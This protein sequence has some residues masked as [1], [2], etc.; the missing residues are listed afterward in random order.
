MKHS[1]R[2]LAAVAAGVT[3]ALTLTAGSCDPQPQQT[4]PC[5]E[6]DGEECDDDPFDF[7]DFGKKKKKKR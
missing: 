5:V 7:D 4:A 6:A 3:V 1:K 2:V